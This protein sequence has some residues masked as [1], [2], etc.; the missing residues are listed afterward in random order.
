M[1]KQSGTTLPSSLSD[2]SHRYLEKRAARFDGAA[3]ADDAKL[4]AT[5]EALKIKRWP[6]LFEIE[7]DFGGL[8]FA[9]ESEAWLIGPYAIAKST[10]KWVTENVGGVPLVCVGRNDTGGL[11]T[12]ESGQIWDEDAAEGAIFPRADSMTRRLEKEAYNRNIHELKQRKYKILPRKADAAGGARRL[13]LPLVTVASDEIGSMWQNE[14]FTVLK[15]TNDV[16]VF[17][18]TDAALKRAVAALGAS[19]G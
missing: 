15:S 5:L 18:K 2:V 7:R 14:D 16:R 4:R 3:R 12:D 8:R 11:F 9:E 17:A 13:E 6:V 10:P 1:K 19:A